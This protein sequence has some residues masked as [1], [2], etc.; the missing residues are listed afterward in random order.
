MKNIINIIHVAKLAGRSGK[1]G[2][3]YDL[4]MA[5]CIVEVLD[6]NGNPAPLIGE[7]VLPEKFKD[8]VPGRYEV[9]FEIAVSQD[10]RINSRVSQMT[11][12]VKPA[13]NATA[14]AAAANL[15]KAS[16]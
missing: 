10:K 14:A 16:A 9:T 1:T 11:P 2:K 7:L 3:D 5:Q 8:T 6:E 15:P 4:R 12:I 13:S